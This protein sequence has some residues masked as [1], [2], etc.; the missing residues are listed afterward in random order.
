MSDLAIID[1]IITFS[2]VIGVLVCTFSNV[3][4]HSLYFESREYGTE[5]YFIQSSQSESNVTVEFNIKNT[6]D[7]FKTCIYVVYYYSDD[8]EL[9]YILDS[10]ILDP[11]S[12]ALFSSTTSIQEEV[13]LVRIVVKYGG[14]EA[15]ELSQYL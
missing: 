2:I 14:D 10:I 6:G 9:H 3:A 4:F 12:Q 5:I 15:I 11:N 8:K 7:E 1:R 13:D